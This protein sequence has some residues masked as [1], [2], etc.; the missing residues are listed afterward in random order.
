[1]VPVAVVCVEGR[2]C[3]RP[4]AVHPGF[5]ALFR[6][7]RHPESTLTALATKPRLQKNF[8]IRPILHKKKVN[9]SLKLTSCDRGKRK[10]S[11]RWDHVL[12]RLCCWGE[13][14]GWGKAGKGDAPASSRSHAAPSSSR[15]TELSSWRPLMALDR[16]HS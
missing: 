1:M 16:K 3:L 5:Q 15:F 10:I 4:G 8:A 9:F 14:A 13:G 2:R 12:F 7:N 11:S 6:R